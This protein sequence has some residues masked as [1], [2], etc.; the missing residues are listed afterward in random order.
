MASINNI[1]EILDSDKTNLHCINEMNERLSNHN[2]SLN[3]LHTNIRSLNKHIIDLEYLNA[4]LN[5]KCHI[6]I[7]SEAW[8]SKEFNPKY[9]SFCKVFYIEYTKNNFRRSDGLV[10]FIKNDIIHNTTELII[11]DT[12]CLFTTINFN[13]HKYGILSLYRSPNGD[14]NTFL[15]QFNIVITDITNKHK[16]TKIII[17]GDLNINLLDTTQNTTNYIDI[18]NSLNF[19][20]HINIITRPDSNTCLDH[21]FS[22][23]INN[24]LI[25]IQVTLIDSLISDHYPVITQIIETNSHIHN[26]NWNHNITDSNS[27]NININLLT[28]SLQNLIKQSTTNRT[29]KSIKRNNPWIQPGIINAIK[30]R[31]K[32][33]KLSKQ[34]PFNINLKNKYKQFR[35]KL[36][37]IIAK[38]K[39]S[40][41]GEKIK[42]NSSNPKKIWSIIKQAT[43]QNVAKSPEINLKI[44]NIIYDS[45]TNASII[46]NKLNDYFLTMGDLNDN[47]SNK[48]N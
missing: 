27:S 10:I 24:S 48:E 16:N 37:E 29:N 15:A 8:I 18:L 6:I 30:K 43:H 46:S 21:V 35:N 19:T 22:N 36:T 20:S 12:N 28:A 26:I 17:I 1:Y 31:D 44:N 42:N 32:L 33:H 41:F 9:F 14:I 4:S 39:Y 2:N 23:I 5:D 13:G 25:T 34:E 40:Y 11:Q 7:A 3:I 45:R 47:I 38:A